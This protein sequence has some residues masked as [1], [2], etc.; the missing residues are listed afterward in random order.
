MRFI[1]LLFTAA[2]AVSCATTTP[3]KNGPGESAGR[4][5]DDAAMTASVNSVIVNDSDA[6]YF[7]I[8]VSTTAGAVLLQ[9][10]INTREAEARLLTKIRSMRGVRSV[11]SELRID[12]S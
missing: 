3:P 6:E 11:T 4:Y 10:S 5:L 8:D 12:N 9:G 2:I 1:V 7:K